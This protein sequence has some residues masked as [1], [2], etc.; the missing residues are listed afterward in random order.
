MRRTLRLVQGHPKLIEL[1]E[2]LA[3][4]PQRLAAQLD[5]AETAERGELD[6]FFRSAKAFRRRR[7]HRQP[8]R[9]DDRH[10]RCPARGVADFFHFLCAI[11][12][13][14]RE[15]WVVQMNWADL[16]KRLGRPDRRPDRRGASPSGRR[17]S[18]GVQADQR[19]GE[20]FEVLIHPGVAEAG[21]AEAG[22]DF[23]EA[24]DAELAST[25]RQRCRT[26][27]ELRKGAVG[28]NDDCSRRP[29]RLSLS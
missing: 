23:Q 28:G 15:S 24:V 14:D 2:N 8:A 7:V 3:A 17:R 29:V 26:G 18:R 25:W 9:L 21:R 22:P 1:A 13:G 27:W 11:E 4:D 10:R 5:R 19:T 20:Q 16:W 6:A 12:E